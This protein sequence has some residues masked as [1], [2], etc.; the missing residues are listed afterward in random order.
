MKK[1]MLLMLM[2][3]LIEAKA[4]IAEEIQEKKDEITLLEGMHDAID[5][6]L[7]AVKKALNAQHPPIQVCL[8]C[9]FRH[10]C[11]RFRE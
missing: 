2:I 3:G 7:Q 5:S 10:V 8:D 1:Q 11:G 4:A 9:P 6:E